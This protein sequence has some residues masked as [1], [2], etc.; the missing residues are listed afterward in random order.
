MF[1]STRLKKIMVYCILYSNTLGQNR[2]V[3]YIR[4]YKLQAV[5]EMLSKGFR[6]C[7]TY[8][9]VFFGVSHFSPSTFTQSNPPEN[10][11]QTFQRKHLNSVSKPKT[12]KSLQTFIKFLLIKP[13]NIV[14]QNILLLTKSKKLVIFTTHKKYLKHSTPPQM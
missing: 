5:C 9:P 10:H 14:L 8:V 12:N 6:F 7:Q 3:N 11:L 1:K 2:M 13:K 4:F